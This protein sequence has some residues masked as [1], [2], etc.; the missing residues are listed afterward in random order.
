MLLSDS[1]F[2]CM[3]HT[4]LL[5]PF[6][7]AVSLEAVSSCPGLVPPVGWITWQ[8]AGWPSR[9]MPRVS[10][11]D[12]INISASGGCSL[13]ARQASGYLGLYNNFPTPSCNL[14]MPG[15]DRKPASL[16]SSD[17]LSPV[18]GWVYRRVVRPLLAFEYHQSCSTLSTYYPE[19][20]NNIS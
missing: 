20:D 19:P 7:F 14:R 2:V 3:I 16:V 6:R 4:L 17:G 8:T 11:V 15:I 12:G 9:W 1:M 10:K 5:V 18:F 13:P